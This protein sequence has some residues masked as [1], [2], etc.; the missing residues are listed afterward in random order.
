MLPWA[1]ISY[2]M[3]EKP[4]RGGLV[5]LRKR[6]KLT[7]TQLGAV[8]GLSRKAIYEWEHGL[9]APKLYPWDTQKL[10]QALNCSLEE[11][12]EEFQEQQSN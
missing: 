6:A 7:Q 11:L 8:L 5:K 12:V 3:S 1:D 4:K 9:A 10:C 2:N